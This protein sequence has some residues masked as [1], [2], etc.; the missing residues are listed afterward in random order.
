MIYS[1]GLARLAKILKNHTTGPE[2]SGG[3]ARLEGGVFP[4]IPAH[5]RSS[6]RLKTEPFPGAPIRL[7]LRLSL[8]SEKNPYLNWVAQ[9]GFRVR[10]SAI[11]SR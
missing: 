6:P 8:P 2:N 10:Q 5:F 3:K 9:Q 7:P 4:S 1:A 11:K